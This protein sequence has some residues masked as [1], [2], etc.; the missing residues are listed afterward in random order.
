[1]DLVIFSAH[2]KVDVFHNGLV[3]AIPLDCTATTGQILLPC[4]HA[5]VFAEPKYLNKMELPIANKRKKCRKCYTYLFSIQFAE[6]VIFHVR[7][8]SSGEKGQFTCHLNGPPCLPFY[9]SKFFNQFLRRV[10][11]AP[12]S[13]SRPLLLIKTLV[14]EGYLDHHQVVSGSFIRNFTKKCSY[15]A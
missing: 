1:M 11:S 4:C 6:I 8:R 9:L 13:L 10:K 2:N 14:P 7:R 15:V 3:Q 5:F 12:Y